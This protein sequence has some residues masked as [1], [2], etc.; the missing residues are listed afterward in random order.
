M[1]RHLRLVCH[2]FDVAATFC[3][4]LVASGVVTLKDVALFVASSP[5]HAGWGSMG[6][7]SVPCVGGAPPCCPCL[8]A[9]RAA[10]TPFLASVCQQRCASG[11]VWPHISAVAVLRSRRRTTAKGQVT[12]S[13][14]PHFDLVPARSMP[15]PCGLT[16]WPRQ[17]IFRRKLSDGDA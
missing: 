4:S 17:Q 16:T 13:P 9:A 12:P 11:H 2:G 10:D 5:R 8:C 3:C 15:I 6:L 14:S 1:A 7:V